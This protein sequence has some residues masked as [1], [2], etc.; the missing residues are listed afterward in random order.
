MVY[1][2]VGF[3]RFSVVLL[4]LEDVED[5]FATGETLFLLPLGFLAG[6]FTKTALVTIS[7]PA[8][9]FGRTSPFGGVGLSVVAIDPKRTIG[10]F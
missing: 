5:R 4:R 10:R 1:S 3:L 7:D 8:A 6:A 9:T 2:V